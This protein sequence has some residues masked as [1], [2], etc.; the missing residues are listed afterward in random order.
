[1]IAAGAGAPMMLRRMPRRA[2]MV[3]AGVLIAVAV[4]GPIAS[5]RIATVGLHRNAV[6]AIAASARSRVPALAADRDWRLSPFGAA[7]VENLS[8]LSGAASG[9]NVILVVLESTGARTMALYGA[10][11]DPTPTVTR[12][13]AESIVFEH[14]YAVYPESIKGLFATLC[15]RYPAID[16]SAEAHAASPCTPLAGE[17]AR[18]GYRTGLFHSGRFA[19]LG[20]RAVVDQQRFETAEDAGAIGGVVES[21][22]GVD[23][24][25][26]VARMVSWIDA[27]ASRPFFLVYL[28]VAGH[29][30]YATSEPGPFTGPTEAAAHRN[31]VHDGDRALG[32]L[33]A[34]LR[35]RQLLDRTLL[36]IVGDHGE[37][38]GEH[39]GNFGHTQFIY[40]ENVR[41]PLVM[42]LGQQSAVAPIVAGVRARRT[43]SAIDLAPTILDA[44]GLP[45]APAYQGT[46]LFA[47]LDRVALFFTDYAL[48]WLGLRDGCWKFHHELESRRSRLFNLCEDPH[49][50]ADVAAVYVDRTVAYRATVEGW[51]AAQAAAIAARPSR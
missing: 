48:G 14:A 40:E 33:V 47:G 30:P 17:L 36:L 50:L 22:F 24:P 13:G 4:P 31:A 45:R 19:Y 51:A 3:L 44:L 1:V 10:V 28:P 41:V 43:A 23:E 12:L 34:A 8:R 9:F 21:S 26:T 16:V 11:D 2:A 38:F 25:S 42:R 7:P 35:Q 32:R 37:A 39:P 15:S 20:M 46:S 18:A 6:T 5:A 29:H 49:E 27:G